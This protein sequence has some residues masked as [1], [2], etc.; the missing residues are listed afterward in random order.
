[1]R[2]LRLSIGL[3]MLA[4]QMAAILY[5]RTV[6]TRYFCWAPFDMQTDYRLAVKVDDQPLT[7]QEIRLRYKRDAKGT[8]NRSSQH[9]MD[10][11]EQTEKRY[12]PLDRTEVTMT[13]TVNGKKV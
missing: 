8:D 3:S 4:F 5:A 2:T 9:I 12:H 1:M 11:V 10:I 6:P 7:D 13:Y